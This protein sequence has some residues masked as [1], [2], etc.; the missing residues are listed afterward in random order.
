MLFGEFYDFLKNDDRGRR[1]VGNSVGGTTDGLYETK[2]VW[3]FYRA[4]KRQVAIERAKA[5]PPTPTDADLFITAFKSLAFEWT[6]GGKVRRRID[7]IPTPHWNVPD[8]S[9]TF[10]YSLTTL[11][12]LMYAVSN[13]DK[14]RLSLLSFELTD[15]VADDAAFQ[16]TLDAM[17]A[18][19]MYFTL[20][21]TNTLTQTVFWFTTQACFEEAETRCLL[22]SDPLTLA[23]SLVSKNGLGHRKPNEWQVLLKIPGSIMQI[24]GHYR[25]TFLDGGVG[26]NC[27]FMSRSSNTMAP[28]GN[29]WGQACELEAL[30]K[31]LAQYDGAKERVAV[32]PRFDHTGGDRIS[33]QIIYCKDKGFGG[34]A[35]L[36]RLTDDIVARMA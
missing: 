17:D 31:G 1:V 23:E 4:L 15:K 20:G 16:K 9:S 19:E 27:W 12:G 30:A 7:H 2:N 10:V 11:S 5:L 3:G 28:H 14:K 33:F 29:E 13:D 6:G 26:A 36:A 32:S 8:L 25:P 24:A 35:A 21:P 22:S 34:D 18:K